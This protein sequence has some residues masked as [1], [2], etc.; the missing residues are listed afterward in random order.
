[1]MRYVKEYWQGHSRDGRLKDGD[2]FHFYA[3][4]SEGTIKEA[5]EVY[6]SP[7]GEAIASKL[8][9]MLNLNWQKDL[10]YENDE[11]LENIEEDEFSFV[12]DLAAERS[13]KT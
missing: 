3:M 10:G 9:E 5:F 13:E 8:P 7:D 6:E 11:L 4:T 2:G 12:K 1:M